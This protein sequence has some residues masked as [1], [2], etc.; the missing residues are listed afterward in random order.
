MKFWLSLVSNM[1]FDQLLE[2]ARFAEEVG[3]H[4]VTVADHLIMPTHWDSKYPY[5][6]DGKIWWPEDTPWLEPWSTISA[7]GAVTKKLRFATNIYLAALRDPF[8]AAKAVSTAA[9]LTGERVTCGVSVGWIKEE[10]D[11][12]NVDFPSRG[13]R[14]D[15]M[16][17]VMRKLWTGK[18]VSHHGE[19]FN[20]DD[21]I[22]CPAPKQPI[23]IWSGGGSKPA[24][25]RAA[26]ND[27]WL[28]LPMTLP[29][30]QA[31]VGGMHDIR[32]EAG[33]PVENFDV[34]AALN[35]PLTGAVVDA[36][37]AMHVHNATMISPWLMSPWGDVRW[38]DEGDDMRSLD[39]KKRGLE[40]F[41]NAV[42][43]KYAQ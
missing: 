14:M 38:I 29:Q 9:A 19:F 40:R 13:R 5:T 26:L 33:L 10:Y 27:G 7:M 42:I 41:A 31:V 21:A 22:M 25:R 11:L 36:M 35:E 6:E 24:L 30:L 39:V 37:Q 28:G 34:C 15:E 1:E 18:P 32:R 17:T 2:I 16:L 12:V 23:K 20:F 8:T 3:F 43:Q 4:G